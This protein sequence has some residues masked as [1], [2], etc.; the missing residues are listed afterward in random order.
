MARCFPAILVLIFLGCDNSPDPQQV[1]ESSRK[2]T[3]E[4]EKQLELRTAREITVSFTPLTP[5]SPLRRGKE[6]A[7]NYFS[8]GPNSEVNR[9]GA[10]EIRRVPEISRSCQA[11]YRCL[12]RT[13]IGVSAAA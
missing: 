6:D 2:A 7:V 4:V 3:A 12:K 11:A 8:N 13:E 9:G 1:I 5:P 10:K